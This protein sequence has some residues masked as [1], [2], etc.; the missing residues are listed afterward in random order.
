MRVAWIITIDRME[1]EGAHCVCGLT[2]P[3]DAGQQ[4]LI[5]VRSGKGDE[6]RMYCDDGGNEDGEPWYEGRIAG[7]YTGF[8]P[9]DHFGYSTGCTEIH[10][11]D[12]ET[13]KWERL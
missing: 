11:K 1:P 4:A 8:E 6:W 3:R 7:D 13:G 5:D 2:G 10:Y 9:L 12:E